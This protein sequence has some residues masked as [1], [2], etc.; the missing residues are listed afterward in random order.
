M[1]MALDLQLNGRGLVLSGNT[2]H[3]LL[4]HVCLCQQAV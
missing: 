3:K 1:V 2:V 4:A